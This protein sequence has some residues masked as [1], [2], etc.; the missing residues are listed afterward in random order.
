MYNMKFRNVEGLASWNPNVLGLTFGMLTFLAA[1]AAFACPKGLRRNIMRGATIVFA[2]G[3]VQSYTRTAII[4]LGCAGVYCLGRFLSRQETRRTALKVCAAGVVLSVVAYAF[5]SREAFRFNWALDADRVPV[6]Q[7][8]LDLVLA[9]PVGYGVGRGEAALA[10]QII[11]DSAHN[12]WIDYALQVGIPGAAFALFTFFLLYLELR[13]GARAAKSKSTF[14]LLE[15]TIV[16]LFCSSMALQVFTFA[17]Q[18]FLI[19]GLIAWFVP[20]APR[21]AAARASLYG[22]HAW[23]R[24]QGPSPQSEWL[25][26]HAQHRSNPVH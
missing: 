24:F 8:G 4:S 15:T 6:W 9:N 14:I 19:I 5:L 20:G 10:D 12:D 25:Y 26:E 2:I 11:F 22:R 17:K 16:F 13:L 3:T 18:P 7:A 1:A 23:G 21:A